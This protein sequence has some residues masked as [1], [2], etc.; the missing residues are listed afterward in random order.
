MT[1]RGKGKA[2]G[3]KP[4]KRFSIT[5]GIVVE[6]GGGAAATQSGV[7]AVRSKKLLEPSQ[8]KTPYGYIGLAVALENKT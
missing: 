4:T 1:V 8:S 6:L 5:I 2:L 3:L 7:M